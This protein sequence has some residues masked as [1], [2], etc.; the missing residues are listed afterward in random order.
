MA[1]QVLFMQDKVLEAIN[2]HL[3]TS[4]T[5]KCP[6]EEKCKSFLAPMFLSFG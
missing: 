3:G 2:A 4:F 5:M 1:L 6:S